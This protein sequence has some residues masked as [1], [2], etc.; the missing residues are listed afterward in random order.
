MPRPL[1]GA[2]DEIEP[3]LGTAD[4]DGE[5]TPLLGTVDADG[6][7][8]PLLGTADADGEATPLLGTA[9]AD[10]EA[11]PLLGTADAD[12]EVEPLLGTR[13]VSVEEGLL[14]E[15]GDAAGEVVGASKNVHLESTRRP[16]SLGDTQA[17]RVCVAVK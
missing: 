4:A 1:L 12:G 10:G 3:L 13:G 8:T 11:T 16:L 15:F 17:P 9:D 7:A 2:A 6:K 14:S 5:A